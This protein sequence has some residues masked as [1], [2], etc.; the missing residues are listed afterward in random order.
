MSDKEII[1]EALYRKK[2]IDNAKRSL[3]RGIQF[4][5]KNEFKLIDPFFNVEILI[6]CRVLEWVLNSFIDKYSRS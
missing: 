5:E 1:D 2:Y 4:I 3:E 6:D